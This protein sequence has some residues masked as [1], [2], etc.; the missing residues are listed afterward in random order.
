MRQVLGVTAAT[1]FLMSCNSATSSYGAG[2]GGGGGYGGGGCTPTST[3]VCMASS[4]FNPATLTV[5]VGTAV[6][7]HNGDA[8]THTVTSATGSGDTYN[9]GNIAGSGTYTHTF[10]AAGTYNYYCMI[11]G[12]DGAPPTGMHGTITVR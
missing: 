5:T 1:V 3:Q 9:S 10:A 8:I 12:V 7:W 11:H 4:T 2:G 6:T